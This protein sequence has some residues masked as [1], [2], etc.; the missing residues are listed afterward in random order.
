[1]GWTASQYFSESTTTDKYFVG[2]VLHTG[3]RLMECISSVID[4]VAVTTV[5]STSVAAANR[6]V[7][8]THAEH[9]LLELSSKLKLKSNTTLWP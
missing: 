1:M 7:I 4:L 3:S 9:S 6:W 2:Y 8:F 5:T